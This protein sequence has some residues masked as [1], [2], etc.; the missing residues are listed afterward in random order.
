MAA[1][2]A[3]PTA[4]PT[5]GNSNAPT[6]VP[7]R[8]PTT[9]PVSVVPLT[10]FWTWALPSRSRETI[11]VSSNA[12]WP[13]RSRSRRERSTSRASSAVSNPITTSCVM[14][15]LPAPDWGDPWYASRSD[16][17]PVAAHE[18]EAGRSPPRNRGRV[19]RVGGETP[20]GNWQATGGR[21][22]SPRLPDRPGRRGRAGR[23]PGRRARLA[24]RPASRS[25]SHLEAETCAR[26]PGS[27]PTP[28][29]RTAAASSRPCCLR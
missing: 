28:G 29:R 2:A 7:T 6:N 3:A 18:T 24:P 12:I 26:P 4:S 15:I 22:A 13:W 16:G 27:G 19:R 5:T 10:S 11:A 20:G 17:G 14:S 9:A 21:P 25:A 1:P 8:P 23:C